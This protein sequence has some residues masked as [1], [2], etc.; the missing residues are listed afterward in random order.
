[1]MPSSKR[2]ATDLRVDD[3]TAGLLSVHACAWRPYFRTP[4]SEASPS[5]RN[6]SSNELARVGFV[7]QLPLQP[8]A[9][10]HLVGLTRAVAILVLRALGH[11]D[12]PLRHHPTNCA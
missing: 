1:M 2:S 11:S 7:L 5:E 9:L 4:E 10:L 12:S 3:T 8:A 6:L